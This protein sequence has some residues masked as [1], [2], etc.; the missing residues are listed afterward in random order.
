MDRLMVYPGAIPLETDILT[1]ERNVMSALG[2]AL[3]GYLGTTTVVDGFTCVQT[4]VASQNVNVTPGQIL[5][6]AN[7]DATAFSS[8][9]AD[10]TH[11]IVKQGLML[12]AATFTCASPLTVGFAVNYLIEVAQSDVDGLPVVIPYFNPANPSIAWSGPAGAGTTNNT[13]RQSAAVVQIKAGVAATAGT[14]VTPTPDAG[15]T[16]MFVVTVA[17][18][19][20]TITSTSISTLATAPFILA[21][22]PQI[23]GNVQSSSWTFTADTGTV[24]NLVGTVSPTP[25]AYAAGQKFQI[26]ALLGNTGAV[27]A[28]F[29]GLGNKPVIYSNGAALTGNDYAAGAVLDL[30]FDGTSFQLGGGL[31]PPTATPASLVHYGVDTGSANAM[32]ATFS[33]AVATL[34]AGMQFEITPVAANTLTAVTLNP[35]ALGLINCF[36][37]DGSAL[38]VGD[39]QPAPGKSIFVYDATSNKM[40]LINPATWIS[41]GSVPFPGL[42]INGLLPS[43][44]AGSS[45]TASMTIGAGGCSNGL[46]TKSI[47]SSSPINW[48]VTNGNA[49]NGYQGGATLP[50]SSTL[51]MFLIWGTAGIATF[52]SLSLTAPTLPTGYQSFR[53]TFPFTTNG[54]GAPIAFVASEGQGGSIVCRLVVTATDANGLS[55]LSSASSRTLVPTSVPLGVPV[56]WTGKS[57]VSSTA[58]GLIG[59][60]TGGNDPDTAPSPTAAPL[61]D[62]YASSGGSQAFFTRGPIITDTSGNVGFRVAPDGGSGTISLILATIGWNYYR[63]M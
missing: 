59:I 21:K 30:E 9:A 27:V 14:Q 45:T 47:L 35:N 15:F 41:N 32:V 34:T 25:A 48:S 54:S 51:G 50:N 40:L 12:N 11:Q 13:S 57:S 56:E 19:Q 29:N 20:T 44:I 3:Q 8:L 23:P 42:P 63:R 46:G 49:A 22:L 37:S 52:A 16:G 43:S 53:M 5:T 55:L 10:T 36:R 39:I 2:W 6:L 7:V 17:Y 60:M 33:P 58:A 62:F 61:G 26:K 1:T 31:T 24:N 18:G 38:A 4:T 28:N